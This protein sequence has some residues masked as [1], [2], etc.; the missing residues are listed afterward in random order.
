MRQGKQG[1]DMEMSKCSVSRGPSNCCS[2]GLVAPPYFRPP[3]RPSGFFLISVLGVG[4]RF[5]CHENV[6]QIVAN[7]GKTP[8]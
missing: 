1:F 8:G 7:H 6:I 3:R 5:L 2:L 4:P